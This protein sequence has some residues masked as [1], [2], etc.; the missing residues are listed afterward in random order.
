MTWRRILALASLAWSGM[1]LAGESKR[2]R[3]AALA[4]L[5]T[6]KYRVGQIW[7]FTPRPGEDDATLLSASRRARTPGSS[8]MSA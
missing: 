3:P 7:K 2:G 5:T 1:T 8:F 6:G 4:E